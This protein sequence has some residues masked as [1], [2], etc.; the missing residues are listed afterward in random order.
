M[1]GVII[2]KDMKGLELSRAY[3]E[4]YG[5]ELIARF[6]PE[7]ERISAGLI[8]YGSE[9]MG[10]D[11]ELSADHDFEPR[12]YLWIDEKT[13]REIGFRLMRAYNA[14]PREFMGYGRSLHSLYG[15]DR[16]GVVTVKD[17]FESFTGLDRPP[18][19][20]GEWLRIPEYALNAATNGEMFVNGSEEFKRYRET[21]KNG[22]PEDVRRKKLAARLAIMAQAGQYNYPRLLTRGDSGAAAL[23]AAEFVTK[24]LEVLFILNKKYAPYYKWLFRAARELEIAGELTDDFE[25]VVNAPQSEEKAERIERISAAII[26]ELKRQ[27]YSS[28]RDSYLEA[29]AVSVN[30]LIR[31]KD[32][33]GLHLM[34]G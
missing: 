20:A 31:D 6:D 24:G 4:A 25:Y 19:S 3:F 13:E 34:E 22:M 9:C 11:D 28:S 32:L 23:A 17:F 18:E 8:G 2:R 12:F 1:K 5:R 21:L 26:A 10:Y 16:G 7:G 14:L 27:G 30:S 29:H 15:A 33:I